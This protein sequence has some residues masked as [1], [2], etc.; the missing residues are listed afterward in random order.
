MRKVAVTVIFSFVMLFV[1]AGINSMTS[2]S[3]AWMWICFG[4]AGVGVVAIIVVHFLPAIAKWFRP[5]VAA[6]SLSLSMTKEEVDLD[7]QAFKEVYP[8]IKDQ[9]DV[10]RPFFGVLD[11]LLTQASQ[12]KI[13]Y[14]DL[15]DQLRTLGIPFPADDAEEAYWHHYLVQLA[16][17]ARHGKLKDARTLL[18][19][20]K[21]ASS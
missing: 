7:V 19:R 18:D 2:V 17:M 20:Q 4:V 11:R 15:T 13:D 16:A 8:L 6:R 3:S 5:R 14:V 12:P 21:K 1:A 9:A 10:R